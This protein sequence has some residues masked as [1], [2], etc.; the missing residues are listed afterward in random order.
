MQQQ[1]EQ[2]P[3]LYTIDDV[4][5]LLNVS[6]SSIRRWIKEGT[7]KTVRLGSGLVRI[8][9]NELTRLINISRNSNEPCDTSVDTKPSEV[10]SNGGNE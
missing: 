3:M 5:Y 4:S 10:I 2:K 7:L 1:F 9:R 6:A 8:D